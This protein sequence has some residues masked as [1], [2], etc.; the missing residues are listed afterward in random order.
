[1]S[2]VAFGLVVVVGVVLIVTTDIV[3]AL[4][5]FILA[6]VVP[7]TRIVIPFWA[8]ILLT[9]TASISLVAWLLRQPLYIGD[10]ANQDKAA[11]QRAR[12]HVLKQTTSHQA[13]AVAK[14]RLRKRYQPA[15]STST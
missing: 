10:T 4:S 9:F 1:M 13:E 15:H 3:D 6:G 8:M 14:R 7:G 12:D 2:R 5:G 11:R